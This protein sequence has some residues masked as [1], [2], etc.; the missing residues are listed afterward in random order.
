MPDTHTYSLSLSLSLLVLVAH[1]SFT[2]SSASFQLVYRFQRGGG[3]FRGEADTENV[4][5]HKNRAFSGD[6]GSYRGQMFGAPRY[7][8]GLSG[9]RGSSPPL[10]TSSSTTKP[11]LPLSSRG[12]VSWS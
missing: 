6:T 11:A 5:E 8:P 1:L 7:Q 3:C 4:H 10:S 2:I 12:L 9:L